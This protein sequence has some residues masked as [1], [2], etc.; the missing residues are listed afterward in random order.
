MHQVL[1][2]AGTRA[3]DTGVFV[4]LDEDDGVLAAGDRL[5]SL[6]EGEVHHLGQAILRLVEIP[7]HAAPPRI[8]RLSSHNETP[9]S[10]L[11]ECIMFA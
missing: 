8:A 9:E 1:L 6:G 4:G 7:G 5:R 10:F 11:L 2:E 3:G